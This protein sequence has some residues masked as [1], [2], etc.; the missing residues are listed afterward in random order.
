MIN[1]VTTQASIP[2]GRFHFYNR[3]TNFQ[4]GDIKRTATEVVY[5]NNLVVF[6]VEPVRQRCSRRLVDDAL[7]VEA[8]DLTR[9][10]GCLT[11]S[12]V[13]VCRNRNDGFGYFRT[14][15]TLRFALQPL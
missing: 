11:L 15:V 10:L 3:I 14:E 2:V 1:I 6:L 12:I 13:E 5:R 9:I 4:D 7:D 8:R